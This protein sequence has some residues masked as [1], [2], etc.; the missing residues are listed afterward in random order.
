MKSTLKT[1]AA[2][3]LKK[4]S[5]SLE[6]KTIGKQRGK[7]IMSSLIWTRNNAN[8]DIDLYIHIM[9]APKKKNKDTK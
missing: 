3:Y 9:I 2:T 4:T 7:K 1:K 8:I 6:I 5:S